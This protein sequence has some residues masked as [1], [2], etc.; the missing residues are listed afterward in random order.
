[1]VRDLFIG[2]IR[3]TAVQST[4]I[5]QNHDHHEILKLAL[6][7]EKSASASMEFQKLVPHN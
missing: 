5:R 2:R 3:D 4:L 7:L 6:E 1:M